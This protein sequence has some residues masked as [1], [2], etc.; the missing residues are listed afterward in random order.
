MATFFGD[1]GEGL[2]APEDTIEDEQIQ[3]SRHLIWGNDRIDG[4]IPL[5]GSN[6]WAIGVTWGAEATRSGR[7]IVWG[8]KAD[9]NIV[10]STRD[11]D[12]IVWSTAHS[13]NIVWSTDCGGA[14]CEGVV[15]GARGDGDFV[16]GT[17][18]QSDNIVWSTRD[19][20]NIVWSTGDVDQILWPAAQP[21]DNRRRA[22]PG[23]H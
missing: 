19:D 18:E 23:G 10:W 3:W 20:D 2:P 5:P 13:D 1:P 14:D 7:P 15:W 16:W 4:G 11:D 8:V 6:A 22:T 17:A 12:N 9:D 21:V